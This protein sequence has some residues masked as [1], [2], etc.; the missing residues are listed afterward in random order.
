M[1]RTAVIIASLWSV[2]KVRYKNFNS[3]VLPSER[4]V[5]KSLMVSNNRKKILSNKPDV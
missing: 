3:V 4:K 1:A 2:E 5:S